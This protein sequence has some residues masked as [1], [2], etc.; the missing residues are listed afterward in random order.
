[1][2]AV[3]ELAVHRFQQA[4]SV[5]TT[6]PDDALRQCLAE[7]AENKINSVYIIAMDDEGCGLRY[8]AGPQVS[9]FQKVWKMLQ[10]EIFRVIERLVE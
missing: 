2:G 1:V 5:A 7:L 10:G 6:R 3:E 8:F 4:P 9:T